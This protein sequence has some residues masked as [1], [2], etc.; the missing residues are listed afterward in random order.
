MKTVN[1]VKCLSVAGL[2]LTGC[3]TS[4]PALES[5]FNSD[6][7]KAVK[8]NIAAHAVEPSTAQKANTFIPA[9]PA[10]TGQARENYRDNTIPEPRRLDQ[11]N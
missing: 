4:N 8:S 7:G 6:W 9:D 11:D 3:A 5:Q 1:K 2:L 10:R